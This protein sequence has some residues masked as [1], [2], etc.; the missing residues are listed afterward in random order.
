MLIPLNFL[1]GVSIPQSFNFTINTTLVSTGSSAA[2]QFRLPLISTGIYDMVVDWGDGTTSTITSWN[3][4]EVT[5]TYATTGIKNISILG[6]CNGW[7]HSSGGTDR[8]KTI[9]ISNWGNG[10]IITPGRTTSPV[11]GAFYNNN[12]LVTITAPDAPKVG[13]SVVNMLFGCGN[14]V[15]ITN[16]SNWNMSGVQNMTGLFNSCRKFNQ[17]VNDWDVSSATSMMNLF[18]HQEER[19]A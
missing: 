4:P 10:F 8:S 9:N 13:I 3:Q 1:K 14:L 18:F 11:G 6:R 15:N 16:V 12:N 19:L 5:H 17:N 2:N 7:L